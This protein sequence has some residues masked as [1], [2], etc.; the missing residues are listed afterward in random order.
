MSATNDNNQRSDYIWFYPIITRWMDNDIYGHINNVTYYSYFDSVVNRYLI[1][2]GG[3]NIHDSEIIA[4][5]VNSN[6]DYLRPLAYP[7]PIEAGLRV[8]KLGRSSVTY[9]LGIFRVGETEPSAY[10]SFVHVFVN[11]SDS[12]AVD[13]P[14]DIRSALEQIMVEDTDD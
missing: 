9:G 7:E 10:G 2:E 3:L 14:G 4:Y 11:R 1:E 8:D 6:C 13:I 5:V 12:K